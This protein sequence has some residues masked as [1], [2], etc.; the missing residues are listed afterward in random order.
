M[1]SDIL[2][3]IIM[4]FINNISKYGLMGIFVDF[5][6]IGAVYSF[7]SLTFFTDDKVAQ[8]KGDRYENLTARAV[9]RYLGAVPLR[10]VLLSTIDDETEADMIFV[11][12]KGIFSIEC[13]HRSGECIS[14]KMDGDYWCEN[15]PNPF[16]QN[17]KHIK[18]IESV[19]GPMVKAKI[20][21]LVFLSNSFSLTYFGRSRSSDTTPFVDMFDSEHR[22]LV[23]LPSFK[24]RKGIRELAKRIQSMP[25]VYTDEEVTAITNL[26]QEH[27]MSK[28]ERKAFAK[29]MKNRHYY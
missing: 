10:N 20:Y 1:L 16:D 21:N 11:S 18:F 2:H 25:D 4:F 12:K 26:L 7:I 24:S 27:E 22:G 28:K 9:K 8:R 15:L 14:A 13:K 19:L 23:Y 3:S 17:Y 29:R 5:L 6:I